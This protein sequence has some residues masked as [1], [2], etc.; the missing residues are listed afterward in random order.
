LEYQDQVEGTGNREMV[1]MRVRGRRWEYVPRGE[2]VS[3]K[4][5]DCLAGWLDSTLRVAREGEAQ[6]IYSSPSSATEDQL[7]IL[8][9]AMQSRRLGGRRGKEAKGSSCRVLSMAGGLSESSDANTARMRLWVANQA[10]HGNIT[11][12]QLI[13]H[14]QNGPLQTHRRMAIGRLDMFCRFSFARLDQSILT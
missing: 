5:P 13:C 11:R 2:R 7:A 3:R 10:S 12:R 8:S 9:Y 1:D 4:A 14:L 6:S